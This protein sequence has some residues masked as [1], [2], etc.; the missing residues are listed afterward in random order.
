M[1]KD[2]VLLLNERCPNFII[3]D[4]CDG[5]MDP[6][7]VSY[8]LMLDTADLSEKQ[9]SLTIVRC[10]GEIDLGVVMTG[11]SGTTSG[12]LDA[13]V[14]T[15]ESIFVS[16]L[17]QSDTDFVPLDPRELVSFEDDR[18]LWRRTG[19]SVLQVILPQTNVLQFVGYPNR[20]DSHIDIRVSRKLKRGEG[21]LYCFASTISLTLNGNP[22]T[23]E[24]I[25]GI[26]IRPAMTSSVRGFVKF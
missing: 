15:Y 22:I 14:K 8:F 10:V 2:W 19:T 4:P 5:A 11:D 18:Q 21:L 6:L 17:D 12:R 20:A 9:D 1:K 25:S 3:P 13:Y 16:S 26:P 23:Q 7:N 24:S